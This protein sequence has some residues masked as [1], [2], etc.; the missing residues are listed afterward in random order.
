MT[1]PRGSRYPTNSTCLVAYEVR[2]YSNRRAESGELAQ[3][4]A[5]DLAL[6]ASRHSTKL[7][8]DTKKSR[9]RTARGVRERSG[10][11]SGLVSRE[12]PIPLTHPST[13]TA[14]HARRRHIR[15]ALRRPDSLHLPFDRLP[16]P[17]GS[18]IGQRSNAGSLPRTGRLSQRPK[19]CVRRG[20]GAR[21]TTSADGVPVAS[22]LEMPGTRTQSLRCSRAF[23]SLRRLHSRP[24]RATLLPWTCCARSLRSATRSRLPRSSFDSRESGK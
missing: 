19:Q 17:P 12:H 8:N 1:R 15:P 7:F 20:T 5:H 21:T 10:P 2:N 3:P 9:A 16:R 24:S 14:R 22:R 18:T 13:R 4:W 6:A 23:R 11:R